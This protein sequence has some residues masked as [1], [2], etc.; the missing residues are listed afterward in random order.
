VAAYF[1]AREHEAYYRAIKRVGHRRD[2]HERLVPVLERLIELTEPPQ[3]AAAVDRAIAGSLRMEQAARQI[4]DGSPLDIARAGYPDAVGLLGISEPLSFDSLKT[5]YRSAVRRN[6]PDL[7]GS[8]EAM[9]MLN[10]VFQFIHALLRERETIAG[11]GERDGLSAA[12]AAKVRN[13]LDYRYSC[14]E[15]LFLALLE[16]WDIDTAFLWLERITSAPWQQSCY[17]QDSWRRIALT[18]PAAKIAGRLSLVRLRE[19]AVQA[20]TIARGGLREA[21]KRGLS[22]EQYIR[23]AEDILA[24]RRHVRVSLSHQRQANNALRLGVIN[25]RQYQNVL[26]RLASAVAAE[27][28]YEARLR[29]LQAG[30]GLLRDLPTDRIAHGKVLQHSLVPEPGYYVNR[31]AQLSNEQQGEYLGAFSDQTT[32]A[33][34]R[35]YTFVRL[36]SLLESVLFYPG[37]VD[38]AA[39]ER[40]ALALASLHDGSG[41]SYGIEVAEAIADL[42]SQAALERQ[43]RA[44]VLRAID[45]SGGLDIGGIGIKVT[46]G[47]TSPLGTPLSAAYFKVISSS[48]NDLSTMQR[49]GRLPQTDED[50]RTREAWARDMGALN[51]PE[52]KAASEAAFAAVG[53]AKTDP[54]A[55]VQQF[56][57]YC[58]FLLDLGRSTLHVEQLQLGF[59][60]D[61]LTATLVRLKRWREAL[62]W[63]E[64]YFAL[65]ERYRGRSSPSEETRL[66]KR[67]E[68]CAEMLRKQAD[69][70]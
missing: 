51:T 37:E 63:L 54:D 30:D 16:D 34:V 67:I 23:D 15:L 4:A 58:N 20:L 44:Q 33:L 70:Q 65:P 14:G 12:N 10:D 66:E 6:H 26:E 59:W 32:L 60:V 7:G 46:F 2:F 48:V 45:Q 47:D 50:R 3:S 69:A 56:S 39:A 29:R 35:K 38:D 61:R 43:S 25:S 22:C 21:Q 18:E 36:V 57:T 31:I 53:L 8:H 11:S 19:Q 64:R 28:D 55:A 1:D 52:A 9:V 41:R 5:A 68:R 62:Q 24:G 13:C 49:I 17:A 27:D 40:E 42:R